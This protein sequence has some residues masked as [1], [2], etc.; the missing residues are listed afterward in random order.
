ML[1]IYRLTI[2][3]AT[4][5]YTIVKGNILAD[6]LVNIDEIKEK[7]NELVTQ[8]QGVLDS[9]Q[10]IKANSRLIKSTSKILDS[11]QMRQNLIDPFTLNEIEATKDGVLYGRYTP[12]SKTGQ[13]V[14][15]LE[16]GQYE[17][18]LFNEGFEPVL[19]KIK[20]LDKANF[21]SE[22][23]REFYLKPKVTF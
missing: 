10:V 19:M 2:G 17:I 1:D 18:K 11:L 20:V 7:A 9:L 15:I 21:T 5:R 8:T 12:N 6:T 22:L 13:F 16:P 3:D 23:K 14:M 4:P